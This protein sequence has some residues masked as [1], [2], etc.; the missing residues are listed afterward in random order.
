MQVRVFTIPVADPTACDDLNRFLA[1]HRVLAVHREFIQDGAASAW[2]FCVEYL[3]GLGGG[4]ANR[5]RQE[6]V[7]YKEVLPPAQFAVFSRLR[8]CRMKLATAEG[9]P[10]FAVCT[11]EQLAAMAKQQT[12]SK[13]ALKAIEG[14]GEAKTEK[15]AAALMAAHGAGGAES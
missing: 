11:D 4:P 8:D 12:L 13:A 5:G 10:A 1:G 2:S 15:Y 3:A 7:D 6:R 9:L 14:I